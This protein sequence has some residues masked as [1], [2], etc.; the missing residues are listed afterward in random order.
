MIS[1]FSVM[2]LYYVCNFATDGV[3]DKLL[4]LLKEMIHYRNGVD[5]TQGF[6]EETVEDFE[7]KYD[8]ILEEAGEEYEY[9][10]PSKYY[11]DGYNLYKRMMK[12]RTA[13]LLLLHDMEVP[14]NN[15][16][17]ERLLR[18]HK[19]K[20]HQVMSFRSDEGIDNLCQCMSMLLPLRRDLEESLFDNVSK[21][22]DRQKDDRTT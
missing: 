10:P 2:T 11:R 21:I 3:Y 14:H 20:Q 8:S 18:T 12:Y 19:R 9:I 17:A 5:E 13:H 4:K 7:K 6:D 16:L 1:P 15:N 22:F